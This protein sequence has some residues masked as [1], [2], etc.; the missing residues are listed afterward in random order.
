MDTD[1]KTID[2]PGGRSLTLHPPQVKRDLARLVGFFTGL[3]PESRKYLRYDV[4]DLEAC[5]RR[6]GELDGKNH[7]RMMAELD[8]EIVGDATLDRKPEGWTRHVA[9]L[10]GVIHPNASDLGIGPILFGEL[11]EIASSS[12]IER[13]SCEVMEKDL[14]HIEMMKSLGFDQDGLL[15]K[16]ARDV[17]GN[18]QNLVIMT[19][20]LEAAWAKLAE[21]LEELEIRHARVG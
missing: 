12:G 4:T 14:E 10:R 1:K 19:I 11:L 5:R 16:Y 15:F 3:P 9:E 17:S 7:W 6:L 13:L 18:L 8:G 2:L 21:Q 20:D